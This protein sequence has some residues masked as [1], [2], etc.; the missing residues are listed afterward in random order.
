MPKHIKDKNLIFMG[1]TDFSLYC[2]EQ[3]YLHDFNIR[4]VYT[5][6]P[7]PAGRHYNLKKTE[8]HEFAERQKMPVYTPKTL[9]DEEQVKIFKDLKPDVVVVVAYG[10]MVPQAFLDLAPFI[11]VHASLLPRWRGAAPIQRA[12]LAG[13]KKSGVTIMRMDAGLDT[14]DIICQ[15]E[16]TIYEETNALDLSIALAQKGA[17]LLE[18]VLTNLDKTLEMATKQ[19]E[20]GACYAEKIDKKEMRFNMS[21]NAADIVRKVK[22]FGYK[23]AAWTEINGKRV[24]ILDAELVQEG[25]DYRRNVIFESPGGKWAATIVQPEGKKPMLGREF[26]KGHLKN[27]SLDFRKDRSEN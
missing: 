1:S 22:A 15:A 26:R 21:D 7:K 14:G 13:D 25:K 9:R 24:K 20:E 12:L 4:A 18:L 2:L 6:E 5:R 27:Q 3:L 11:N 16:E 8:I 19:P 23:P 10:L 17:H